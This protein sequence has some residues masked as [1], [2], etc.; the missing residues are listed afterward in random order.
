M[1]NTH[2][3]LAG[4]AA[5]V[6]IVAWRRFRGGITVNEIKDIKAKG[7]L[8]LDVRTPGEFSQ[9]HAPGSV[10]IPLDQLG[11]RLGELDRKKPI[12]VACASGVRSASAKALLEQSGFEDVHNAGP[13]QRLMQD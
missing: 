5:F 1:N 9:G 3:I 6:L 10:N 12:L 2:L 8:L 4:A 13:W 11:T 7:A